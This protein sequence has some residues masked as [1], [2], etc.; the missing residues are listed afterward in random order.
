MRRKHSN[1]TN[2]TPFKPSLPIPG[3]LNIATREYYRPSATIDANDANIDYPVN[4]DDI[5]TYSA[6]PHRG[7]LY[8]QDA[9]DADNEVVRSEDVYDFVE[10]SKEPAAG[11]SPTSSDIVVNSD[12]LDVAEMS[13]LDR[14]LRA[15]GVSAAERKRALLELE[16]RRIGAR[17]R[18]AEEAERVRLE[19]MERDYEETQRKGRE[20]V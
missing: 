11:Y 16:E 3:P 15:R 9:L 19:E 14:E 4:A 7:D 1:T 12:L 10:I 20:E 8:Q 18:V 5:L 2:S 13:A 6:E 17:R